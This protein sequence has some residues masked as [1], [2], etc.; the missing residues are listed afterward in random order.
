[1]NLSIAFEEQINLLDSVFDNF[2]VEDKAAYVDW[3]SQQFFLVQRS[4]RYLALAASMVETTKHKEFRDWVNHL[5]DELDHDLVVL[6]DLRFLGFD[7]QSTKPLPEVRALTLAMQQDIETNGPNALFGYML[8]LEG[9]SCKACQ[10]LADRAQSAHGGANSYLK[11]HAKVDEDHYP[12]G[13][14]QVNS[15]SENQK[16]VVL[17]NL[18]MSA[19]LYLSFMYALTLRAEARVLAGK[20]TTK[21][22]TELRP[23]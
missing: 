15:L 4:T 3:L 2:P 10:K 17:D 12:E 8:M 20:K 14:K 23:L 11:L 19:T 16:Q 7:H 18:Q 21:A 9:L 6:K 1:M 22:T 13:L 5:A